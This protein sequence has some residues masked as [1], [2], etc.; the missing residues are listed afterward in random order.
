MEALGSRAGGGRETPM[1]EGVTREA[2]MN[3]GSSSRKM[4]G[5]R[6]LQPKG[7]LEGGGRRCYLTKGVVPWTENLQEAVMTDLDQKRNTTVDPEKGR[8]WRRN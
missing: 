7:C 4:T 5:V 8:P 2:W 3:Q 1:E 6:R